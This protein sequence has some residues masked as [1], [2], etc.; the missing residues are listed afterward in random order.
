MRKAIELFNRIE[1]SFGASYWLK[2]AVKTMSKRDPVDALHDAEALLEYCQ[3]RL[4][5]A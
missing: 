4:E 5:A 2:A 1:S 3:L